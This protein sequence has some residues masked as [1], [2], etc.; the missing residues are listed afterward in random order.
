MTSIILTP[1]GIVDVTKS[2][3][4]RTAE[5]LNQT[6]SVFLFVCQDYKP[7]EDPALFQSTKT[8]RG[9]LGPE[10]KVFSI[11]AATRDAPLCS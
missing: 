10:W 1:E 4:L 3:A 8:A 9:P 2:V 7:E 6:S 11:G 5:S